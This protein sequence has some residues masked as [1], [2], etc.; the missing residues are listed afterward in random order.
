M[1]FAIVALLCSSVALADGASGASGQPSS[2]AIT[3]FNAQAATGTATSSAIPVGQYVNWLA[4]VTYSA[5]ITG[6]FTACTLQPQASAD[7]SNFVNYGNAITITPAASGSAQLTEPNHPNFW[8]GWMKWVYACSGYGSA[9]TLTLK[10]VYNATDQSQTMQ[11]MNHAQVNGAT[12]ST[13]ASGV[14]KVGIVGS[15]GTALDSTAG[16]LDANLKNVGGNAVVTG[17][18]NGSQSIDRKSVV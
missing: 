5:G 7:N 13:S 6:T 18:A 12:I 4:E 15:T 9:G 14:Q 11:N 16:V 2:G 17:G 1:R 3:V 10:V 8:G